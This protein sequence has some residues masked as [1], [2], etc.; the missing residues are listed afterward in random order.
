[1]DNQQ[2]TNNVYST[3]LQ[4]LE[5]DKVCTN[6]VETLT[7]RV[8][9]GGGNPTQLYIAIMDEIAGRWGMSMWDKGIPETLQQ[10][11]EN[12]VGDMEVKYH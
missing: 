3:V 1:M 9:C 7:D 5:D 2:V 6:L 4:K 12:M 11:I 10:K 8:F